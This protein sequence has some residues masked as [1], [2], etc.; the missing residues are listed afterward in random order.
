MPELS[1][2][3]K[4]SWKVLNRNLDQKHISF[5]TMLLCVSGYQLNR[6]IRL[7]QVV[8]DCLSGPQNEYEKVALKNETTLSSTKRF[9]QVIYTVYTQAQGV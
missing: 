4:P 9:A 5:F 7:H 2:T 1:S 3:K 6:P 8:R